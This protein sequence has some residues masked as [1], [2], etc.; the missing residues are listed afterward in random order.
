MFSSKKRKL[1]KGKKSISVLTILPSSIKSQVWFY[2][3]IERILDFGAKHLLENFVFENSLF[4]KKFIR[5][6]FAQK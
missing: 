1:F 3:L 4:E 2:F 5:K 6:Q